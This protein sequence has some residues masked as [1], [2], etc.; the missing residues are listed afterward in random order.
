ML[1]PAGVI[2]SWALGANGR[3]RLDTGEVTGRNPS[4]RTV[5]MLPAWSAEHS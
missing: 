3:V 4:S 5:T 2:W 1:G